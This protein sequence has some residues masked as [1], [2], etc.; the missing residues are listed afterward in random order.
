MRG[1]LAA[2]LS[3]LLPE[4]SPRAWAS[5]TVSRYRKELDEC[6]L[7]RVEKLCACPLLSIPDEGWRR[8]DLPPTVLGEARP[9]TDSRGS[10]DGRSQVQIERGTVE[11][12]DRN[13]A[14]L[15][16]AS[17]RGAVAESQWS[18]EPSRASVV[19]SYCKDSEGIR[20]DGDAIHVLD[21]KAAMHPTS[22]CS[23]WPAASR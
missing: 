18:P 8:A 23:R 3:A 17:T 7:T 14:V 4:G 21:L 10:T 20:F 6:G 22:A 13:G 5:R 2:G 12:P 19:A 15:V 11:V 9:R 16:S 1:G